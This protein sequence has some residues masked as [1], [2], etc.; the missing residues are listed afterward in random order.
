VT[1]EQKITQARLCRALERAF[2]AYVRRLKKLPQAD[3][4]G[5]YHHWRL[6]R[7]ALRII[8]HAYDLGWIE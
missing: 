5:R 7:I 6:K 1:E 2:F 3:L 8:D 4:V